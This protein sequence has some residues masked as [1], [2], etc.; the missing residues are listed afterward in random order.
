RGA[1]GRLRRHGTQPGREGSGQ[2]AEQLPRPGPTTHSQSLMTGATPMSFEDR[3]RDDLHGVPVP[4]LRT[5]DR[6]AD[7]ALAGA[8]RQTRLRAVAGVTAATVGVASALPVLGDMLSGGGVKPGTSS[9]SVAAPL[10]PRPPAQEWEY[11]DPLK[12]EIDASG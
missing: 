6:L 12:Y 9:C 2:A 1:A 10:P 11:F 4:V 8:R 5:P 7:R 3:L